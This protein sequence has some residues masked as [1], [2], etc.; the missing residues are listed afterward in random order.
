MVWNFYGKG[1]KNIG[2]GQSYNLF[3]IIGGLVD[4]KYY[5]NGDF[6]KMNSHGFCRISKFQLEKSTDTEL[7]YKLSSSQETQMQFPFLFEF[8]VHYTLQ[9]NTL[10][11]GYTIVNKDNKEML[12]SVGAHPG[13]NCP[14]LKNE[15]MDDYRIVFEKKETLSGR[16]KQDGLLTGERQTIIDNEN[17]LSLS[18]ERFYKG[19]L[20]LDDVKSNWLEICN[21]KNN[22]IIRITFSGFPYLGIWSSVNDGPF[23]CIEPWF[24]IDSTKGDP[25]DFYKKEGLL[26]L[27]QGET[28]HCEYEITLK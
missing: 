22:H 16:I 21:T 28:F 25:Y 5:L 12:Y 18:H 9:D 27:P 8:Y 19:A 15:T 24:G 7:V 10:I 23:V 11:H 6:Y 17:E 13:F 1:M 4:N 20:I 26:K 3:P 14:L 2:P